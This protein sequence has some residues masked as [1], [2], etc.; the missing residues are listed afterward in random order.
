[1]RERY[2]DPVQLYSKPYNYGIYISRS[3]LLQKYPDSMLARTLDLDPTAQLIPVINS[4][5]TPEALNAVQALL[6]APLEYD[7][8]L[9]QE[10][11]YLDT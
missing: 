11:Q 9:V 1:M 6:N 5:I 7:P 8:I 3:I 4:N 2:L 10:A